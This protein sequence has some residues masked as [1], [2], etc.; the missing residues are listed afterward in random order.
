MLYLSNIK[1]ERGAGAMKFNLTI[2]L[3]EKETIPKLI[4]RIT[5]N[6]IKNIR[7]NSPIN[8]DTEVDQIV[9]ALEQRK[10][11]IERFSL[12]S[13]F[14][15]VHENHLENLI[16]IY[17]ACL[18][19]VNE[20]KIG[21]NSLPSQFKTFLKQNT[22][23]EMRID[24]S[25]VDWI[26]FGDVTAGNEVPLSNIVK[27]DEKKSAG[28]VGLKRKSIVEQAEPAAQSSQVVSPTKKQ[29]KG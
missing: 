13:A 11:V 2:N 16:K 20:L 7:Y 10:T 21:Y 18:N 17:N 3:P 6:N 29:K 9:A 24:V 14:P 4:Q 1:R 15:S 19:K 27:D 8:S 26:T 23:K 5:D 28:G 12:E 25:N 22:T